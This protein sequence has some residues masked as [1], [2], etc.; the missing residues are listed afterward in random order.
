V[1]YKVRAFVIASAFAGLAGGLLVHL[2]Q[3]CTPRSFTFIKSFEAVV[4]VV[5]G[6]MGSVSGSVVSALLLTFAL[7]GLREVEQYRMVGYAILLI[8]LMLARPS[9]LFGTREIWDLLPARFRT[10][11][12]PPG[13]PLAGAGNGG[14]GA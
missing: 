14:G 13:S 4:M 8:A 5:L 1:S 12:P 9:G 10:R 7:E 3:L 2:I 11:G 6:G